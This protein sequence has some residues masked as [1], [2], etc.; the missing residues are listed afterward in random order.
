MLCVVVCRVSC[1]VDFC[2]T[3]RVACCLFFVVFCCSLV[4]GCSLLFV[5]V[6]IVGCLDLF[7]I[8]TL[9]VLIALSFYVIVIF[10]C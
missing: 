8:V 4:V 1:V 3:L 10:F 5:V 2:V 7:A 9:C 6:V